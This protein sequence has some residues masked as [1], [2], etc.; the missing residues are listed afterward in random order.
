MLRNPILPST[1]IAFQKTEADTIKH[2]LDIAI[3]K[4]IYK[5]KEHQLDITREVS[6]R[7]NRNESL[8]ILVYLTQ[9][10][11][12]CIGLKLCSKLPWEI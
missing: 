11:I 7:A 8:E 3:L 2:L 4:T 12:S 6:A 10:Y 5:N 1:D 9:N